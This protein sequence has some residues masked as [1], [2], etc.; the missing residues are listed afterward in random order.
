MKRS[1]LISL[2]FFAVIFALCALIG[3]SKEY[4][5][6]TGTQ[7]VSGVWEFSDGNEHFQ[8]GIDSAYV[9]R[10]ASIKE[11]H[12]EGHHYTSRE[13]FHLVI[14][15]DTFLP[16]TYRASDYQ[17]ALDYGIPPIR[18]YAA[19]QTIGEFLI[20]ISTINQT[21]ITGTF[22]GKALKD[23]DEL[24]DLTD[25]K[26][27]VALPEAPN[28]PQSEGALGNETG[29]CLPVLING[30]YQQGV[31]MNSANT[32]QVQVTVNSVGSYTITTEP[33]NGITFSAAGIFNQRGVQTVT[34]TASGIPAFSGEQLFT[35]RYGN[36]TC[37]F[38]ISF[39]PPTAPDFDYYPIST[40]SHWKFIGDPFYYVVTPGTVQING[41]EYKLIGKVASLSATDFEPAYR[42][43]KHAGNYYG[44][45]DYAH[46]VGSAQ[47]IV[48]ETIF[49][50][51]NISQGTSWNGPEFSG[52][53][54]GVVRDV[55]VRFT[56]IE[57]AMSVQ[58]GSFTLPNVIKV[59]GEL[60]AGD[61]PTGKQEEFWY[62][63]NVG[64]VYYK[65]IQGVEKEIEGYNIM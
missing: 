11:L 53:V 2:H 26:F 54:S 44:L 51:D 47:P 12:L 39:A 10:S 48:H 28:V 38:A 1:S 30:T 7:T 41:Q 57:K 22:S 25:G 27:R 5:V 19:D 18:R 13:K 56:I 9:V 36:S 29:N 46:F 6:E 32:L 15:A 43:R 8:G 14:Y 45:M 4:S 61:T 37:G 64:L 59:R 55:H 17:A 20:R 42:I 16:G 24:V 58:V 40:N 35:L 3:C 21:V 50:K 60:Y 31:A 65:D 34:L 52:E 33:V 23:E 63:Y 62:A 49:L